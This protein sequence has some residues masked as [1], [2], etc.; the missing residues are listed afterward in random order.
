MPDPIYIIAPATK[1]L[2][3]VQQV[4]F[5]EIGVQERKDLEAWVISHPEV[6]G[7]QLLIITSEFDR[8]DKSNRRLDVLALDEDGTLVVVE[9]KLDLSKTFADQ[10]A[11]RY[12]AFCSTMTMGQ[13]VQAMAAYRKCSQDEAQAKILDFLEQDELPE[14]SNQPRII[15]AAGALDD[16]ELTSS[17]LWL[18]TFGVDITCIEI[19]PYRLPTSGELILVP[20]TIIPLPEASGYMVRVEQKQAEKIQRTK[21]S[22]ELRKQWEQIAA[23]FNALKVFEHEARPRKNAGY[24]PIPVGHLGIHYEWLPLKSKGLLRVALHFEDDDPAVNKARVEQIAAKQSEIRDGVEHPFTAGMWGK[25][26]ATAEFRIP[27]DET[28][29]TDAAITEAVRVMQFLVQRTW[30]I[31]QTMT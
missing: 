31:V 30:P 26:W 17:V 3:A 14:L 10:Q 4:S 18:R 19:K 9:L 25:N 23:G 24:M 6:L 8:F 21:E 16:E 7:E 1:S 29:P 27:W 20:R 28:V 13:V 2:T 11:I 12:A 22:V 5:A 15:L